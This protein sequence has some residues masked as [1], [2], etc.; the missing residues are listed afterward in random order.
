MS[1]CKS[2]WAI[3]RPSMVKISLKEYILKHAENYHTLAARN[4]N[5]PVPRPTVAN[6]KLIKLSPP[7]YTKMEKN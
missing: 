1:D 5:N 6:I 2:F 7:S 3:S 4:V